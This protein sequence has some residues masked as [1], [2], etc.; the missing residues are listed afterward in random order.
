MEN[1]PFDFD[2]LYFSLFKNNEQ[3]IDEDQSVIKSSFKPNNFPY[4]VCDGVEHWVLWFSKRFDE[5]NC[6][7]GFVEKQC[8]ENDNDCEHLQQ[9]FCSC[10]FVKDEFIQSE[11]ER[12]CDEKGF[13]DFVWYRNPKVKNKN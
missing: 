2:K 8:E 11:L 9:Q 4:D 12:V 13:V 10:H 3:E 7:C 5:N 6:E 1:E